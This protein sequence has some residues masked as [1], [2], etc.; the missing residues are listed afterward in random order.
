MSTTIPSVSQLKRAIIIAEQIQSLE[1][2]L[3]SILGGAA[4][5]SKLTKKTAAA[6]EKPKR[7]YSFS[8][9]ARAKIAAA[10][11]ARWARQKKSAE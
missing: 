10:Q 8:P 7:K 9:E 1:A 4:A 2:E 6:G 11:K 3:A 5:V